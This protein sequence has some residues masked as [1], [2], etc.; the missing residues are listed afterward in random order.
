M[1]FLLSWRRP[2]AAAGSSGW[3]A[4]LP[5]QQPGAVGEGV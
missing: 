4:G 5:G 3:I 1:F 2:R